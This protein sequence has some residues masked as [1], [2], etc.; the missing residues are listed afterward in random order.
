MEGEN[1]DIFCRI[2]NGEIPSRVVFE[3]EIVKVIM[4]VNPRSNGHLLVIPKTH[5]QDLFDI[6]TKVLSHIMEVSKKMGELL[7]E[8][9]DCKGITLE[10]NNGIVQ[11]VKHFHLHM[12]PK[13]ETKK[14]LEDIDKV[15][16]KLVD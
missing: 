2:I 15:F 1:M 7:I 14:E 6:D 3:D 8:K 5:Y 16:K 12:I 9:L 11:E 10:E 4:D 13:Y